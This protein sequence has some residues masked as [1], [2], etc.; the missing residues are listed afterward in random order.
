LSIGLNLEKARAFRLL[1][2]LACPITY[3]I[4][5]GNLSAPTR[6]VGLKPPT[7]ATVWEARR[8][9]NK[10]SPLLRLHYNARETGIPPYGFEYV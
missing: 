5:S 3:C 6:M 2:V 10:A 8:V 9:I 1:G 7:W 4:L